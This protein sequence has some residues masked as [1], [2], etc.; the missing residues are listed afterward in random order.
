MTVHSGMSYGTAWH[1]LMAPDPRLGLNLPHNA[2]SPLFPPFFP[3]VC[4]AE[5]PELCE[6]QRIKKQS[7]QMLYFNP[8]YFSRYIG[9]GWTSHL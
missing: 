3:E 2:L 8:I 5:A 1:T 9:H 6:I 4:C 7:N